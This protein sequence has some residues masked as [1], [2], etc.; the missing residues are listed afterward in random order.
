MRSA[1]GL[2]EQLSFI[3]QLIE[4]VP[5]PIFFKAADGRYLGV[6]K[7]WEQFF[8]IPRDQFI[9]KSVF[10]LY[11][12]DQ[13]L[14]S[15]HHARDQELFTNP[16][17][18]SYEA[19]IV[20][21][22]G[23]VHHTIY[24]KATFNKADGS[25]A[26]LI[27]TIT[28]VNELKHAEAAL[29]EGEGRFRDL[30]ELSSDWYW[31]QDADFRFTHLSSKIRE[32]IPDADRMLGR[33]RWEFPVSGVTEEEWQAHKD[34]LAAHAPF[35]DFTYQRYDP[36]GEIRVPASAA[37]RSSTRRAGS[38]AIVA[39]AGTSPRKSARRNASGTWPTTT[40]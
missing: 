33:M 12:H 36:S 17:S 22:D 20:A 37:G 19:A 7:A 5:Q 11:P 35:R 6:N 32:F 25:V 38:R 30:T 29:R 15:K 9:G 28:D 40:P 2:R 16:G 21:A 39:P 8:G 14:A 4:A 1:E 31:E 34:L 18:Q 3:Q 13:E 24:N 26:G 10:E 27:G 23:Q